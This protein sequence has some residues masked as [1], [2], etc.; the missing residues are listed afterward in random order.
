MTM[1]TKIKHKKKL[2]Q[3]ENKFGKERIKNISG[4]V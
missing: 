1:I 4:L 2:M 3:K